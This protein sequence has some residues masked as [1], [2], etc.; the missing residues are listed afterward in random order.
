VNE[1]STPGSSSDLDCNGLPDFS[2]RNIP[3]RVVNAPN[4]QTAVKYSKWPQ[5][6]PTFSIPWHKKCT[7]IIILDIKI[8]HLAT[9][10]MIMMDG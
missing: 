2:W 8:L 1:N 4:Y 6:I 3:K 10:T 7:K 9:L 5:N